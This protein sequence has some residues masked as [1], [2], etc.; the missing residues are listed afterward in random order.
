MK[1][2]II[3]VL[4]VCLLMTLTGCKTATDTASPEKIIKSDTSSH[5]VQVQTQEPIAHE[6]RVRLGKEPES[7]NP[8]TADTE[9]APQL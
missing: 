3:A 7:L 4:F 6:V 8:L 2:G 1:K 9:D 5:A